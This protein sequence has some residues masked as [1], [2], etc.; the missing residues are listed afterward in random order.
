VQEVA[1]L[2]REESADRTSAH[3][4]DKEEINKN[5]KTNILWQQKVFVAATTSS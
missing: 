2:Q 4:E 1:G 3:E 5:I